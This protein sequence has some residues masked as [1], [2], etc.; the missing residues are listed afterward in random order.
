LEAGFIR[1][2]TY[3]T[4]YTYEEIYWLLFQDGHKKEKILYQ[5]QI[6][7]MMSLFIQITTFAAFYLINRTLLHIGFH[8]IR[9]KN[10]YQ[11]EI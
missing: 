9:H 3:T 6:Y 7:K 8:K 11:T 10:A 2:R 1:T 4:K 5:T